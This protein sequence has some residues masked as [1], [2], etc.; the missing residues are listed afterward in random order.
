MIGQLYVQLLEFCC[1]GV[2]AG[3]N[4]AVVVADGDIISHES[5]ITSCVTQLSNG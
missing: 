1:G 4:D 3:Q 2:L 5:H